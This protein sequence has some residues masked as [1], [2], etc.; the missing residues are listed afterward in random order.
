MAVTREGGTARLLSARRPRAPI[1]AATD[2][3]EVARRLTLWRGVMP[4]VCALDGDMEAV[5]QRI[6]DTALQ[7]RA[8]AADATVVFVNTT[9]D[10]DRSAANFVRLRRV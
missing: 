8:P 9:P 5:I 7:G 3:E 2:Q 4:Q 10:L 1:F 6:I